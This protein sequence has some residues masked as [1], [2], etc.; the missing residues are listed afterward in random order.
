[1]EQFYD[2]AAWSIMEEMTNFRKGDA[3]QKQYNTFGC[4]LRTHFEANEDGKL[5]DALE[6]LMLAAYRFMKFLRKEWNILVSDPPRAK[7]IDDAIFDVMAILD[8]P[9]EAHIPFFKEADTLEQ[10][11]YSAWLE[12][13]KQKHVVYCKH[14]R[15]Y[16]SGGC[17]KHKPATSVGDLTYCKGCTG[18][19]DTIC[20][21]HG[22]ELC[23]SGMEY[24]GA[25]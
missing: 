11:S 6:P 17:K 15:N 12:L 21:V 18:W 2:I 16:L 10:L 3:Y 7:A 20:V 9:M 13:K 25:I 4:A 5:N 23:V 22:P 24:Y 19:I 1:M 8:E 14:C